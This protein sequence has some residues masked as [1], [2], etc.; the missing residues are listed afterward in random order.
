MPQACGGG[1]FDGMPSRPQPRLHLGDADA[2]GRNLR[3]G[4]RKRIPDRTVG[5]E[6]ANQRDVMPMTAQQIAATITA[7]RARQ[8]DEPT[9]VPVTAP[10]EVTPPFAALPNPDAS[11]G[12]SERFDP[13]DGVTFCD[14]CG[15]DK[16][17]G[18]WDA[19]CETGDKRVFKGG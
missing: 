12:H 5:R 15:D 11:R 3:A 14:G 4:M 10:W 19:A 8:T 16:P 2:D 18:G 17:C 7:M 1:L 9:G 13:C 6:G